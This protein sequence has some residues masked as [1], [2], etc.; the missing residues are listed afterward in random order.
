MNEIKTN[1]Q[2]K[3]VELVDEFKSIHNVIDELY[4]TD[5]KNH[6][7]EQ[8][9]RNVESLPETVVCK[10]FENLF[11]R[12][13][14]N[15][16]YSN[17]IIKSEL[18]EYECLQYSL[19]IFICITWKRE[20]YENLIKE[21]FSEFSGL[22]DLPENNLF[23]ENKFNYY[24][25]SDNIYYSLG[26]VYVNWF[27]T[28]EKDIYSNIEN[29]ILN[30]QFKK[31]HNSINHEADF[32]SSGKAI[33]EV[34][35]DPFCRIPSSQILKT[36][37]NNNKELEL[38]LFFLLLYETNTSDNNPESLSQ[39]ETFNGNSIFINHY[40]SHRLV[41]FIKGPFKI[42]SYVFLNKYNLNKINKL[43][44]QEEIKSIVNHTVMPNRNLD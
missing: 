5:K 2:K 22:N 15:L 38:C 8:L 10:K 16:I 7:F 42:I 9:N 28:D 1:S 32:F 34:E 17:D 43:R 37:I 25:D 29:Y 27:Y 35:E 41:N 40:A 39:F 11:I 24:G 19:L 21:R 18:T 31:I 36:F 33:F 20:D 3:L 30:C 4:L 12:F 13:I 14:D 26:S 44:E 6:I 23:F